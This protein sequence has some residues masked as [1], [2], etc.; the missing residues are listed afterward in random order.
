MRVE[1]PWGIDSV[2]HNVDRMSSL[3]DAVKFGCMKRDRNRDAHFV[4]QVIIDVL[5][6]E[7][8]IL[9]SSSLFFDNILN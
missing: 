2:V 8:Y 9:D 5:E 3:F 6:P 1:I 4:G 7:L